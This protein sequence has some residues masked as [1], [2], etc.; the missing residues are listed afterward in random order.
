M[1]A[2]PRVHKYWVSE[3]PKNSVGNPIIWQGFPTGHPVKIKFYIL[4]F[5]S[6]SLKEFQKPIFWGEFPKRNPIIFRNFASYMPLLYGKL[7]K[8]PS[9]FC[10]VLYVCK[11]FCRGLKCHLTFEV[12]S[13]L[14]IYNR[15]ILKTG[16]TLKKSARTTTRSMQCVSYLYMYCFEGVVKK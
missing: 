11:H 2:W 7:T 10:I 3:T 5:L 1:F 16:W 4:R 15:K 6:E 8:V 13:V 9:H 14:L 12:P